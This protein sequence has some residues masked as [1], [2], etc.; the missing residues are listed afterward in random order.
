MC[1]E[2]HLFWGEHGSEELSK[3]TRTKLEDASASICPRGQ[4]LRHVSQPPQA[5]CPRY[6]G[7]ETWKCFQEVICGCQGCKVESRGPKL[8]GFTAPTQCIG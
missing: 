2:A 1:T 6:E 3:V 5:L 4:N 7:R 8:R